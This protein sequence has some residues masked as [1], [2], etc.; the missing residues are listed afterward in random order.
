[1][2]FWKQDIGVYAAHTIAVRASS[3]RNLSYFHQLYCST[4]YSFTLFSVFSFCFWDLL[5]A[6]NRFF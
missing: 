1:M 2:P 6:F 4:V 3:S 5:P